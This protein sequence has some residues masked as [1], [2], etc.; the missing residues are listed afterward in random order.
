M[1]FERVL[2]FA[3]RCYNNRLLCLYVAHNGVQQAVSVAALMHGRVLE[4]MT[5]YLPSMMTDVFAFQNKE[6]YNCLLHSRIC[7]SYVNRC[8]KSAGSHKFKSADIEKTQ[9]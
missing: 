4:G 3:L 2:I 5:L 9:T 8:L 7:K 6:L 1:R